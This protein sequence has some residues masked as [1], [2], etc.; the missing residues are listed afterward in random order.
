M[1]GC[2]I[3]S[4]GMQAL[5]L[6]WLEASCLTHMVM[7]SNALGSEAAASLAS[8]VEQSS[9][10]SLSLAECGLGDAGALL[11]APAI[12]RAHGLREMK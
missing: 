12:T 11:L 6:A 1:T 8:F 4:V 9:L 5:N 3:T 7:D 2:R 10:V